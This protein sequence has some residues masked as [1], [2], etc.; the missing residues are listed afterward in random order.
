MLLLLDGILHHLT[1]NGTPPSAWT[2]TL[3]QVPGVHA[4]HLGSA[5]NICVLGSCNT[6]HKIMSALRG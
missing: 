3:I 6:Y 2:I 5:E 4:Y 1:T